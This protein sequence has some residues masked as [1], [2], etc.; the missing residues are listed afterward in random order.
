MMMLICAVSPR[1]NGSA[2][3][4]KCQV[5]MKSRDCRALALPALAA[6][7]VAGASPSGPRPSTSGPR[8]SSHSTSGVSTHAITVTTTST[9]AVNPIRPVRKTRAGTS[10]TPPTAAPLKARLMARPRLRSNHGATMMLRAA[11]LMVAHPAA[12]RGNTR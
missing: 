11:P 8:A 3:D 5:R 6:A 12:R 10:T 2:T 1:A 9:A 4:Q 7:G